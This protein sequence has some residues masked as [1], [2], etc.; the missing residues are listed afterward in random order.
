MAN[1]ILLMCIF[2]MAYLTVEAQVRDVKGKVSDTKNGQPI[3]GAAVF[4]VSTNLGDVTDENGNFMIKAAKG[5]VIQVSY[6]GYKTET[7][8]VGDQTNLEVSLDTDG[9]LL[10]EA[11]ITGAMGIKMNTRNLTHSA[12]QVSGEN[13]F[14]TGRNDA[15]SS[16]A[17]R[18]PGLNMTPTS[19]LAGSSV[20]IQLRGPS[21]I[22]GNNQPLIVVDG[23]PIDNRTFSEGALT[24]DQPNR[25]SDYTNRAGDLNPNDIESIV[26]LKGAEAAALY[27]IDAS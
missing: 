2:L 12:T 4:N 5:N 25:S 13:L 20:A 3:I 17:G 22:D 6:L 24:T 18:V 10:E 11:V 23:L 7:I 9:V 8:T 19:G 16:L 15:L 26:V 21:S 14:L 27:G 1:K